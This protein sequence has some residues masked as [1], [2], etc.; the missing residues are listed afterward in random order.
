MMIMMVIIKI[1]I[2]II[3]VREKV[4]VIIRIRE[5]IVIMIITIIIGKIH[6]DKNGGTLL[7]DRIQAIM[8]IVT[9]SAWQ[10]FKS[11]ISISN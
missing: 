7:W 6:F 8:V 5:I 1:Q 10:F 4:K 9:W 3:I 11:W 2:V